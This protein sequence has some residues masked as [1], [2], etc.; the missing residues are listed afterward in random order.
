MP[1]YSYDWVHFDAYHR[2]SQY[3]RSDGRIVGQVR[4]SDFEREAGWSAFDESEI[5]A[6]NLGRFDTERHAQDAVVAAVI[7]GG[8]SAP[9][10]SERI[11][12]PDRE[13]YPKSEDCADGYHS[14]CDRDY[15]K[16]DCHKQF[17][18]NG[19]CAITVVTRGL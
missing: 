12:Q 4:G 15:C 8:G 14:Q 11:D 16:C 9:M 18:L 13:C 3:V 2:T 17:V 6:V 7:V 10:P 5:P 1:K 19:V